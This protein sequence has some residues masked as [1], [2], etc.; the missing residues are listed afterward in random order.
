MTVR[1][2]IN[3]CP[4]CGMITVWYGMTSDKIVGPF[5]LDDTINA[6]SYLT[7]LEDEVWP[8]II[9]SVLET[10]RIKDLMFMQDKA[11]PHFA[12]V[13]CEWLNARFPAKRMGRRNSQEWPAKSP[14][15]TINTLCL[16]SL[17][18]LERTILFN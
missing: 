17:G 14:D 12:V 1:Y 4:M 3:D 15:L 16:F 7:M 8:I 6:D 2:V 18:L 10:I 11:P 9:L 13:V 5:I